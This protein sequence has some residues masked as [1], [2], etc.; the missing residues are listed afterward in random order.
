MRNELGQ[1]MLHCPSYTHTAS[2]NRVLCENVNEVK[3]LKAVRSEIQICLK[4]WAHHFLIVFLANLR[5]KS[6]I[7]Q[8]WI[9]LIYF[10]LTS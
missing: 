4:T 8:P 10:N 6:F 3:D 1:K 5:R 7:N 2:L 9:P